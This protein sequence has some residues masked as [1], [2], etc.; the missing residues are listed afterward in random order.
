M[1][2]RSVVLLLSASVV[3]LAT[4]VFFVTLPAPVTGPPNIL[5]IVSD[6]Q[7]YADAGFQGSKDIE[8]PHLDR[9]AAAGIRFSNGYASHAYC[10]PTR[11]GLLTG[12]YQQRFGYEGNPLYDP[13]LHQGLPLTEKL[14]PEYL[15]AAGYATG[16]IGKWHLGSA[17][18]FAPGKR[19]FQETFGVIGGNHAYLDWQ[20]DNTVEVSSALER[21]G[22]A[23]D[24]PQEHLTTVFGQEAAA[25]VERHQEGK[26][27]FLYLALTAPHVPHQPTIERRKQFAHIP[28]LKRR[29][30]A[31]QVSL[32]DD[33]IG[34][35]LDALH[36]TQQLDNTLVIFLSDNGGAI[37][38]GADNAPFRAGKGSI[39]E[40]GVRV[41]Y[42][43]S[44]PARLDDA[45]TDSRMVSS[46]DVFATALAAAGVAM[47][48]DKKYDSVNLIPF[49]NGEN[50]STPHAQLF[51]RSGKLSAVREGK[52]KL[53]RKGDNEIQ[54]Y[55]LELDSSEQHNLASQRQNR[56]AEL[57]T[58]LS[59]WN[60]ELME[61]LFVGFST[62]R[63]GNE[64]LPETPAKSTP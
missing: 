13:S 19:G 23:I 33:A 47:P 60:S 35:T 56:V 3:V 16:W 61:P 14:L 12:R 63:D 15:A 40:G 64:I 53:V 51:W 28:D 22:V 21:N 46:L 59:N 58:L 9:L 41:P 5:L 39:Y 1:K 45:G 11:A 57:N 18:E 44:W 27:W 52:W 6:D 26:P 25:F 32:M 55:D 29:L 24:A 62:D 8:T 37:K 30:Y 48:T 34:A 49:L 42:V 43:I 38:T 4:T 50:T 20:T 36:D 31:A 17:P 54:L 7:G 10:S 2:T